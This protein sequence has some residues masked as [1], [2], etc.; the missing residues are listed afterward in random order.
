MAIV[1][2]LLCVH[3]TKRPEWLER[4]LES[5]CTQTFEDFEIILCDDGSNAETVAVIEAWRQREP[6]L[7]VLRN[8]V[9]RGLAFSLNRC[10]EVATGE[11]VVR[12]DDDD[13]SSPDRLEKQIAFAREHPEYSIIGTAMF[14]MDD[15]G[16]WGTRHVKPEPHKKDFLWGSQFF[17]PTVLMRRADVMRVAGYRVSRETRRTE[18]YDLFVRM[19]AAGMK[20]YNLQEPLYYYRE[21]A[22]AYAKR[23]YR[24]RLDE[25]V[26]RF[27]SF[28]LL[29]LMPQ[30]LPFVLKPLFVG[31][32]PAAVMIRI[33][34]F[35]DGGR[36]KR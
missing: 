7:R 5:V 12:Q 23:R 19:Y 17:H 22:Q 13:A 26:L 32:I 2:F 11:Y 27:H 20:G 36:R 8:E 29:G 24:H 3:N 25:A 6:R 28:M 15:A 33:R 16:G 31:L 9:N 18:D 30:G 4:S 1:S 10:L 34:N 14:L 35:F 21:D